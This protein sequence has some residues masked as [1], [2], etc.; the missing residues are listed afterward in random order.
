[1]GILLKKEKNKYTLSS[2]WDTAVVRGSERG[3]EMVELKVTPISIELNMQRSSGD[4]EKVQW[5]TSPLIGK[6]KVLYCCKQPTAAGKT[7]RIPFEIDI[8]KS[9]VAA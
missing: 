5:A 2:K 8:P 7:I 1:M 9:T 4:I 6:P 3:S